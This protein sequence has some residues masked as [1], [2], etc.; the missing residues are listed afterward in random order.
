[1][2]TAVQPKRNST[3]DFPGGAVWIG[4]LAKCRLVEY[5]LRYQDIFAKGLEGESIARAKA[6]G[7]VFLVGVP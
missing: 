7:S 2:R 4:R 6:R 1:M 5:E 3:T